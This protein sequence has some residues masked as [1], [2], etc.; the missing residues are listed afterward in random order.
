MGMPSPTEPGWQ[1][2]ALHW[3][4]AHT[5]PLWLSQAAMATTMPQRDLA[6]LS[7]RL[8]TTEA[9]ALEAARP[10]LSQSLADLGLPPEVC[11]E[12]DRLA[13]DDIDRRRDRLRELE[14]VARH[15]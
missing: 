10:W 3:M 12:V 8:R 7:W 5:T 1:G 15:L 6:R 14:A 11:E 9:R 4:S 2:W 13:A